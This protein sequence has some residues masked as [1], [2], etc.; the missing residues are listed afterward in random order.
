[1][2]TEQRGHACAAVASQQPMTDRD[3]SQF[4]TGQP[5]WVMEPDGSQ[6]PG[7][8]VGERQRSGGP[9]QALVVYLDRPGA[10]VVVTDRLRPR[11]A[12]DRGASPAKQAGK[13][14][15]RR[16]EQARQRGR[17]AGR[18][19]TE[20]RQTREDRA[21]KPAE[22]TLSASEAGQRG[23]IERCRGA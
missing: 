16:A 7:E 23:A 3:D 12:I 14:A 6:R 15:A 21:H 9:P 11:D 19:A 5:V 22:R 13:A 17:A 10:E 2:R 18:R 1:M 4:H 8:Y 20:L